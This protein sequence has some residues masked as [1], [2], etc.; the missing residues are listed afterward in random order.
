MDINTDLKDSISI[1]YLKNPVYILNRS[2]GFNGLHNIVKMHND[3]KYRLLLR[4]FRNYHLHCLLKPMG[5]D[6]RSRI[7]SVNLMILDSR[8]RLDSAK[9]VGLLI[10]ILTF[11]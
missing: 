7:D 9:V 8:S 10:R 3:I 4:N 6:T 11:G 5:L 2:S 1:L